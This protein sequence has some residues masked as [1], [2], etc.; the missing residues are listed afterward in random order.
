MSGEPKAKPIHGLEIH[1]SA[2]AGGVVLI[3]CRG[4][5]IFETAPHLK[6]TVKKLIPAEKRITLDLIGVTRMDSSGLGALVG[7]YVSA[8]KAGCEL[9]LANMSRPIRE[10]LGVTNLLSIFEDVGRTGAR[11]S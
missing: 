4:N 7:L 11:L 5:L 8:R 9:K 10:L 1:K 2:D 6:D 3:E